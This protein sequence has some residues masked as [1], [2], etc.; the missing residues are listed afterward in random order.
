[1]ILQIA[2]SHKNDRQSCCR[3]QGC[4]ADDV[5]SATA[6][7]EDGGDGDGDSDGGG[8]GGVVAVAVQ[9]DKYQCKASSLIKMH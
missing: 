4:D 2:F 6:D 9:N 5:T 7:T 1:M 3:C 8:D